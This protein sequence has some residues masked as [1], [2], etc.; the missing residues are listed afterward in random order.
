MKRPQGPAPRLAVRLVVLQGLGG[1]GRRRPEGTG[2][3]V[4]G[5]RGLVCSSPV[6]ELVGSLPGACPP[7]LAL[8]LFGEDPPFKVGLTVAAPL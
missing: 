5:E 2:V 6:P 8:R 3:R 4:V 7:R 1:A